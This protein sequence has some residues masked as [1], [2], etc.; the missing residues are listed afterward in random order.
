MA[1]TQGAAYAGFAEKR[2][3]TLAPGQQ[4]DF[5]LIDRDITLSRPA[6]IR[7]TQVLE[8][9]VGGKRVYVKGSIEK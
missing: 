6:D 2:F 7:D 1:F 8:T 9:W 3:G 5:V 4:A